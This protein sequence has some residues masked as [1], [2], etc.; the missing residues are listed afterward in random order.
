[1]S[2]FVQYSE[3]V[4]GIEVLLLLHIKLYSIQKSGI[5]YWISG[6]NENAKILP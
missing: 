2:R 4:S 1:M 6:T 5:M 3:D